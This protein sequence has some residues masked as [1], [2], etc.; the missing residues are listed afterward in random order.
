M[1]KSAQI[2][3]QEIDKY[4][5]QRISTRTSKNKPYRRY[6]LIVCEG[7]KTEP[8]YFE[9]LK[10]KLPKEM[11]KRI[12][13]QGKGRNTMSLLRSAEAEVENR[14]SS[15]KPPYYNIWLVFDKDSFADNIFDATISKASSNTIHGKQ[16]W[17]CAWSNEAFE[18]WYLLHFDT[19]FS[20]MNRND[21]QN[22]IEDCMKNIGV[23]RSYKKNAVDMYEL[24]EPLQNNAIKNAKIALSTQNSKNISPSKMNPATKVHLLV[25][26][27]IRHIK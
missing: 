8:N 15:N 9:S 22:K 6:Y 12:S 4:L 17:H 7:E 21:Y 1:A 20:A 18:L 27:L 5:R 2:N 16:Y 26:E 25:E 14:Y 3:P 24:L 23:N 10:E 11:V 13:I 19:H